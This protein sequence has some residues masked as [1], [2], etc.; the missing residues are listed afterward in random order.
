MVEG[1]AVDGVDGG[2]GVGVGGQQHAL[3]RGDDLERA[4]EELDPGHDRHLL[5]GH[6]ERDLLVAQGH[7]PQQLEAVGPRL[8]PQHAV[9]RAVAAPQ[10]A[11]DGPRHPGLVVDAEDHRLR[12]AV[13]RCHRRDFYSPE[14]SRRPGYG[15]TV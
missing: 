14:R 7:L 9:V 4:L 15:W 10:V 1:G 11:L 13:G 8:G 6:Q 3:G 2:L 12:G 5:V